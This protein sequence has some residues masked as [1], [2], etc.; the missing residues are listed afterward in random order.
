[1]KRLLLYALALI[2][3]VAGIYL[4]LQ[5]YN[6]LKPEQTGALQVSANVESD[7]YLDGELVGKTPF[8]R[9][10]ISICSAYESEPSEANS[11]GGSND[12]SQRISAGKHTIKI[13]PKD[14][15]LSPYVVDVDVLPGVMTAVDR[16][17]LP[18]GLSSA[19]ILTLEKN[20]G[21]P[22]LFVQS[23]PS[24]AVVS[25]DGVSAG[26]TPF[27][28]AEISASEHV[29]EIQK[30]GFAKKTI[31][32]R[33]VEGYLLVVNVILGA[34]GEAEEEVAAQEEEEVIQVRI[35]DT[36]VGFLRVRSGPGI[37]NDEVTTVDPGETFE[38]L[39]EENG[40]IEL[41]I[42]NDTSGWVSAEYTERVEDGEENAGDEEN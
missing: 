17:F 18:D 27:T 32:V 40:W 20:D 13:V 9:G 30:E 14:S 35:L 33:T 28:E 38:Q 4:L 1:M 23:I 41:K 7:V 31:R 5:L 26:V 34:E 42:D 6:N 16:T 10:D 37:E 39:S 2:L 21:E 24:N 22:A 11:S 36:P 25:V 3:I 29:L 8:C 19:Y 12:N 15:S